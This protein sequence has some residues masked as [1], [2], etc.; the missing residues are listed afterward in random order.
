MNSHVV[1]QLKLNDSWISDGVYFIRP[2]ITGHEFLGVC[3]KREIFGR[4]PNFL[5]WLVFGRWG[6]VAVC[7]TPIEVS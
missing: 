3:L 6:M 5:T 1:G 4:K 7:N 2:R